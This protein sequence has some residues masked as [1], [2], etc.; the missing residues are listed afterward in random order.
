MLPPNFTMWYRLEVADG[1]LPV[2]CSTGGT[3]HSDA[4]MLHFEAVDWN[5]TVYVLRSISVMALRA[6]RPLSFQFNLCD[7]HT[8]ILFG[9]RMFVCAHTPARSLWFACKM[10]MCPHF[11]ASAHVS[12]AGTCTHTH[13]HTHVREPGMLTG[14]VLGVTL[15]DTTNSLST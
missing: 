5:A 14:S 6:P 10:H 15:E 7:I 9:V 2:G 4:L 12:C 1:A 3:P 8:L 13:T 11:C